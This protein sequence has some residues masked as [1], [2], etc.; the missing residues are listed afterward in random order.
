MTGAK[1]NRLYLDHIL[2]CIERV[3][4]Y[5]AG[6]RESFLADDMAQD[7]VV[8]NLQ[9]LAESTQRLSAELKARHPCIDWRRISQF[10]NFVVHAYMDIKYERIWLT[11]E[12]QLGPLER[13]VRQSLADMDA[14]AAS[15][16]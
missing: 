2:S 15:E 11:V 9:T 13:V 8:R 16:E 1:D 10:R 12:Q 4:R 7:A 6:G 5:T 3:L 14:T